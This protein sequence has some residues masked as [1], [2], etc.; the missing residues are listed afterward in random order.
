MK[1]QNYSARLSFVFYIPNSNAF[2]LTNPRV[3]HIL[4]TLKYAKINLFSEVS[5]TKI[6][7]QVMIRRNLVPKECF[8]P[9]AVVQELGNTEEEA[10]FAL[11]K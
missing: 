1:A 4:G 6:G 11:F 5:N 7:S 2:S 8:L 3:V 9:E 10:S